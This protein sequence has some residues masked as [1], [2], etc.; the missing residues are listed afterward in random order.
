MEGSVIREVHGLIGVELAHA[1][2]LRLLALGLRLLVCKHTFERDQSVAS[3]EAL[4]VF[5]QR[6]ILVWFIRGQ[7]AHHFLAL[8]NEL[9]VALGGVVN[10]TRQFTPVCPQKVISYRG[11]HIGLLLLFGHFYLLD[12]K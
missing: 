10:G 3:F 9:Q 5:G 4:V 7:T 2:N 12:I 1:P 6:H 8:F 11:A